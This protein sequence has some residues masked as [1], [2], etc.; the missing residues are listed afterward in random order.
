MRMQPIWRTKQNK[1]S[2][3]GI[4]IYSHVQKKSYCSVLQICC[5]HT[6]V[7]GIYKP[8]FLSHLSGLVPLYIPALSCISKASSNSEQPWVYLH[9]F[10]RV[11][12]KIMHP[13]WAWPPMKEFPTRSLVLCEAS[14]VAVRQCTGQR[15]VINWFIYKYTFFFLLTL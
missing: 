15:N 5:I 4:E 7:Q 13:S 1:N 8:P 3:L 12:S 14:S 6:D 11:H 9:D 2:F 10:D